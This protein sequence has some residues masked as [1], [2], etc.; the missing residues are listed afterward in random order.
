M[1]SGSLEDRAA[2]S[3]QAQHRETQKA[4][5]AERIRLY[6]AKN[7]DM[8]NE[9]AARAFGVHVSV[10]RAALGKPRARRKQ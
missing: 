8:T 9:G 4:I 1:R 7:E 6:C 2:L 5:R 3:A 10:I